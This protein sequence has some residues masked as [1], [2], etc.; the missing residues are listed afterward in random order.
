MN[1]RRRHEARLRRAI[2]RSGR[3]AADRFLLIRILDLEDVREGSFRTV[4]ELAA[5]VGMTPKTASRSLVRLEREECFHIVR[6]TRLNV[7]RKIRPQAFGCD[8]LTGATASPPD[9]GEYSLLGPLR[10]QPDPLTDASSSASPPDG[11]ERRRGGV[12]ADLSLVINPPIVPPEPTDL[13]EEGRVGN[14]ASNA[15]EVTDFES[16]RRRTRQVVGLRWL[17]RRAMPVTS[18]DVNERRIALWIWQAAG[19][20]PGAFEAL[21]EDLVGAWLADDYIDKVRRPWAH[22]Q[23]Q[24]VELRDRIGANGQAGEG[25]QLERDLEELEGQLVDAV[26]FGRGYDEEERLKSKIAAVRRRLRAVAS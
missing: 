6:R 3:P 22:F 14:G 23:S 10:R 20:D 11:G 21:L 4:A 17:A 1:A 16:A 15:V 7:G 25:R 24:L 12:G 13:R 8:P 9:G 19:E 26:S 18:D 2:M 5:D